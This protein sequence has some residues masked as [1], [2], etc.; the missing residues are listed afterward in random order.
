LQL[1]DSLGQKLGKQSASLEVIIKGGAGDVFT[2]KT[3]KLPN[4]PQRETRL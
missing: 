4:K 3:I 1:A 2:T